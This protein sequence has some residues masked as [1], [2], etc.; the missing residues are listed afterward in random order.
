MS[1][2]HSEVCWSDGSSVAVTFE[3]ELSH[4][5]PELRERITSAIDQAIGDLTFDGLLDPLGALAVEV[6]LRKSDGHAYRRESER[7]GRLA[8]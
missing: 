3:D 2:V 4:L 5:E 8:L 6:T 1:R 7:R